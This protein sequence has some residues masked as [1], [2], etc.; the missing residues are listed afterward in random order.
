MAV[1]NT[2]PADDAS[3]QTLLPS[4][5]KTSLRGV[6][7]AAAVASF[8]L[9]AVFATA[10]Q[11]KVA[12]SAVAQAAFQAAPP[13]FSKLDFYLTNNLCIGSTKGSIGDNKHVYSDQCKTNYKVKLV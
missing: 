1:F 5:P 13:W 9:G 10:T 7:V 6:V 2:I 4:K 8:A 3:T 12:P 11:S